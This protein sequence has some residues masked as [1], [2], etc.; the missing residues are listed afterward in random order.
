MLV[1][2]PFTVHSLWMETLLLLFRKGKQVFWI[3]Q[4][5]VWHEDHKEILWNMPPIMNMP[6]PPK[7]NT[8]NRY[9]KALLKASMAFASETMLEARRKI[10]EQKSEN[11]DG[12]SVWSFPWWSWNLAE[13]RSLI[14]VWLCD[15][16]VNGR[17]QMPWHWSPQ[18]GMPWKTN[19]TQKKRK[20]GK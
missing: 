7:P 5:C 18:Q 2:P 4:T 12:I 10:H 8:Y 16:S 3:E 9:N 20:Y 14:N 11:A 13:E 15:N 6:P 1:L 17:R 19:R